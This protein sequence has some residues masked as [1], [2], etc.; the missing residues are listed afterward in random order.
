MRSKKEL[1]ITLSKLKKFENPSI[2]LEQYATPEHIAADWIW[3]MALKSEVSGRTILDAACGSGILGIALLLMGVKKIYFLDK[4]PK[5]MQICIQNYNQ[6]KEKY[7]IGR[8]EFITSDIGLFDEQVDL[9]IQNP[10]FGTKEEHIDK[11]FL[12]K[13]FSVA[14]LVYSMHKWT[15]LKFVEAICK[16]YN[17][18]ISNMWKYDFPIKAQFYFH[19]KPVQYIEVGL[20]RIE[21]I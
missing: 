7:E 20:W 6:I 8:A 12:E 4:D 13:A 2:E 9:V 19:K 1:E 10:P 14:P 3:Q 17:F 21:K 16:D 15:T 5:I 18:K 11:A